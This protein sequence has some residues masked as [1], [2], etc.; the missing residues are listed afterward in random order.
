ML[1]RLKE[2]TRHEFLDHL[3][4]NPTL[5]FHPLGACG[6]TD[7]DGTPIDLDVS[8]YLHPTTSAPSA[9][10]VISDNSV[11]YFTTTATLWQRL[12]LAGKIALNTIW[13]R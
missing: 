3:Y 11:Q 4:N 12:K 5:E 2:V 13:Q 1:T 6:I 7:S 9:V 10:V 8:F